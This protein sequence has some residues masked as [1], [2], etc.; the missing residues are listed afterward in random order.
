[1]PRGGSHTQEL[2]LWWK[3]QIFHPKQHCNVI[4]TLLCMSNMV[5]DHRGQ[6]RHA[7]EVI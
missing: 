2:I 7:Q 1:M 5:S 4:N 3:R 6:Q